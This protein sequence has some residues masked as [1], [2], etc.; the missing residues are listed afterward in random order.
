VIE[1]VT[2]AADFTRRR[3]IEAGLARFAR[4]G[5]DGAS[6]RAIADDAQA[7]QAA[8]KYHFGNKDGLY[9]EVLI[10]AFAIFERFNRLDSDAL[11]QLTPQEALEMFLRQNLSAV[12]SASE[13]REPL[14]VVNWEI[15]NRTAVFTDVVAT[16]RI[17]VFEVARR[18][19]ALFQP[20]LAPEEAA[21][22]AVWLVNQPFIFVRN[23]D[24]MRNPPVSVTLDEA[25]VERLGTVL[26]RLVRGGLEARA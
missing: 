1:R 4:H 16:R 26:T 23:A 21:L 12:L 17:P 22:T 19:V 6:V 15:V 24:Q 3:L 2:R 9:R 13:L 11:V 25:G 14:G 10:E 8:I 7:N 5:F 20:G 18:I